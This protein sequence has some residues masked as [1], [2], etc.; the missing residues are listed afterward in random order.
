MS[1][2]DLSEKVSSF[3]LNEYAPVLMAGNRAQEEKSES[4]AQ[5][6][7]EFTSL[8]LDFFRSHNLR[9]GPHQ[10]RKKLLKEK[11]SIVGRYDGR[12]TTWNPPT[13][14]SVSGTMSD[15]L[16]D[17][18]FHSVSS[19]FNKALNEY[20]AG[21]LHW[22]KNEPYIILNIPT[23]LSWNWNT[24]TSSP[25]CGYASFLQDLRISFAKNPRLKVFV[26]AGYY[27]FATPF[28]AQQYSLD[29]LFLPKPL[30]KNITFKVYEGGHMMY[31]DEGPRKE[32]ASDLF[33]FL[34]KLG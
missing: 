20:L 29:H 3:A 5:R 18:T 34:K 7:C 10:F 11:G 17:P 15:E 8:P 22:E 30:D 25:G 6:L 21:E 13:E 27:D 24:K 23:N 14:P 16:L 9:L 31:L 12:M 32:L 28:F 26:A 4:I 33:L 1:L 2:K 19:F